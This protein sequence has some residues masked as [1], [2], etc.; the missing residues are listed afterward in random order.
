VA[1]S[2][3]DR[4]A[5]PPTVL[6]GAWSATGGICTGDWFRVDANR[7]TLV[8]S[9]TGLVQAMRCA[10]EPAADPN[11]GLL[12][13]RCADGSAAGFQVVDANH[14]VLR[15]VEPG[16]GMARIAAERARQRCTI[17]TTS[18]PAPDGA[19]I[20]GRAPDGPAMPAPSTTTASWATLGLSLSPGG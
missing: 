12:T 17:G 7:I 14:I 13:A 8:E 6:R 1:E 11:A 16:P 10:V 9:R 5:A 18:L 20:E 19:A 2:G 4:T 15:W 3:G